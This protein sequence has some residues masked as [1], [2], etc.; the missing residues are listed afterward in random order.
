MR[1]AALFEVP[2][3]EVFLPARQIGCTGFLNQAIIVVRTNGD[4]L[5]YAASLRKAVQEQEPSFAVDSMMTMEERVMRALAKPRLYAVVL[6]G[7]A[8][9]AVTIAAVGLFGVL[10]HNVAQRA[11]EIG[12][13][14]ALGARPSDVVRLVLRHVMLVAA[15]G[16]AC[17]LWTAYALSRLLGTVLYGVNPHD[18]ASFA[19]VGI[20]LAVVAAVAS[21]V[22]ARRAARLDPW[23]VLR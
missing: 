10:S 19:A 20:A 18:L 11:R 6:A 22:P 2:Q 7:F 8:S 14:T 1:Q 23:Q 3:P 12:V 21:V 17:G 15:A 13:R 5:P 16:I 9:F 4:P